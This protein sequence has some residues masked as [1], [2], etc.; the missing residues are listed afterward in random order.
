MY[1]KKFVLF[2]NNQTSPLL[3]ETF[4]RTQHSKLETILF[5]FFAKRDALLNQT[6]E[7]ILQN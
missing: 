7:E 1:G 5:L 3:H 6:L 2:K 4:M